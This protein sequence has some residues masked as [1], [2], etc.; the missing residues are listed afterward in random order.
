MF[1][2]GESMKQLS[3]RLITIFLLLC[4]FLA[5][6]TMLNKKFFSPKRA[7]V[8]QHQH[9]SEQP[10]T[11]V[12]TS[13]RDNPAAFP[14]TLQSL[15]DQKDPTILFFFDPLDLMSQQVIILLEQLLQSPDMQAYSRPLYLGVPCDKNFLK[16]KSQLAHPD[17]NTREHQAHVLSLFMQQY[18]PSF[19][20]FAADQESCQKLFNQHSVTTVPTLVLMPLQEEKSSFHDKIHKLSHGKKISQQTEFINLPALLHQFLAQKAQSASESVTHHA[21]AQPNTLYTRESQNSGY[22]FPTAL[23]TLDEQRIAVA[24]PFARTLL[25]L[26]IIENQETE[27]AYAQIEKIIHAPPQSSDSKRVAGAYEFFP[28]SLAYNH[29]QKILYYIN[30]ATCTVNAYDMATDTHKRIMGNGCWGTGHLFSTK[31][32]PLTRALAMPIALTLCGPHQLI[33]TLAGSHQLL[34]YDTIRKRMQLFMGNGKNAFIPGKMPLCSL[35]SPG[36]ICVHTSTIMVAD[37]DAGCIGVVNHHHLSRLPLE[38]SLHYPSALCSDHHTIY[39][40]DSGNNRII[41]YTPSTQ[42]TTTIIPETQSAV[43]EQAPAHQIILSN[44][45]GITLLDQKRVI[46]SDTEHHRL[47]L[48]DLHKH[49][50]YELICDS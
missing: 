42:E 28:T 38:T 11:Q 14:S 12:A 44:P 35:M 5:G 2:W 1:S 43:N 20:L 33:I 50:I 25:I 26:K 41:A 8:T 4:A 39:I 10:S 24:Q 29:Q 15:E 13:L 45:Q 37:Y 30:R 32:D 16:S 49:K 21:H 22:Y 36:S 9:H 31:E 40:A 17:K 27:K 6:I 18:R 47:I 3:L 23:C 48:C 34:L 46:I 19:S 7:L